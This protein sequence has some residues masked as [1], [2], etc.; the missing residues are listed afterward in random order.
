MVEL[1]QPLTILQSKLLSIIIPMVRFY[2]FFY[3]LAQLHLLM[4]FH[5]HHLNHNQEVSVPVGNLERRLH[6][7]LTALTVLEPRLNWQTTGV[8][9]HQQ[10]AQVLRT[11]HLIKTILVNQIFSWQQKNQ[12]TFSPPLVQLYKNHSTTH[13]HPTSSELAIVTIGFCI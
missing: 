1:H 11:T 10:A 12:D 4:V 6:T 2:T 8:E 9:Q 5:E 7:P 13:C 3:V